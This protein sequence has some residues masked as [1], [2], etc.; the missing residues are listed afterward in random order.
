MLGN[1]T[2]IT[3]SDRSKLNSIKNRVE[4]G[5]RRFLGHNVMQPESPYVHYLPNTPKLSEYN[6]FVQSLPSGKVS[7]TLAEDWSDVLQLPQPWLRSIVE[8]RED[9]SAFAGGASVF[10]SDTL[11]TENTDFKGDW[12][13]PGFSRAG[14]IIR[15][16]V[17]WPPGPRTV[18]VIY[19]A[20]LT[21]SELDGDYSDIKDVVIEETVS[22]FNLSRARSSATGGV[23]PVKSESLGGEYS[24]TYE[25]SERFVTTGGKLSQDSMEKLERFLSLRF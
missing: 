10:S 24:V 8:V 19:V 9:S 14:Q 20:G 21:A 5:V 2:S 3:D 18:R 13:E 15:I 1:A 25:T 6:E 11:L 12:D 17:G 23:G 7:F 22:R 4:N 16:G